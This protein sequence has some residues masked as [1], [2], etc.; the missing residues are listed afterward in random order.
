[1]KTV[2]SNKC[3][4][5]VGGGR[6]GLSQDECRDALDSVQPVLEKELRDLFHLVNDDDDN[7]DDD[8]DD[9][10]D[11]DHEDDG[12]SSD[13]SGASVVDGEQGGEFNIMRS[14]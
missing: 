5:V 13:D 7:D 10:D 8:D 12:G 6:K 14:S 3:H 2:I 1:M 9:D 4:F 11:H